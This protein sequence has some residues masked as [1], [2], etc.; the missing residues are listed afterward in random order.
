MS[1]L[2]IVFENY[3]TKTIFLIDK[4]GDEYIYMLSDALF[5]LRQIKLPNPTYNP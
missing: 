4:D 3:S 1:S 2:I 5:V